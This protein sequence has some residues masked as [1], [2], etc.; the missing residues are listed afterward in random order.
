[1][2]SI[3]FCSAEGTGPQFQVKGDSW[4]EF[5]GGLLCPYIDKV[6]KLLNGGRIRKSI[7]TIIPKT[8]KMKLLKNQK[9]LIEMSLPLLTKQII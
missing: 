6:K 4:R 3:D 9:I 2:R 5:F 1:M 7:I 8:G